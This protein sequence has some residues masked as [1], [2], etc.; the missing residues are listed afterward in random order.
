MIVKCP[1][2]IKA[3]GYRAGHLNDDTLKGSDYFRKMGSKKLIHIATQRISTVLRNKQETSNPGYVTP[4]TA[5][6]E[7]SQFLV[8]QMGS[9]RMQIYIFVMNKMPESNTEIILNEEFI[10]E[11]AVPLLCSIKNLD[12]PR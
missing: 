11:A 9:V 7:Y 2:F 10:G 12:C 6:D 3:P 1:V 4:M 5:N 8:N